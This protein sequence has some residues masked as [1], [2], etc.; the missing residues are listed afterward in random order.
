[1]ERLRARHRA[2]AL[3]RRDLL[4]DLG[5]GGLRHALLGLHRALGRTSGPLAQAPD[6]ARLREDEQRQDGDPQQRREGDDRADLREFCGD[7]E[8]EQRDAH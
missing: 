6:L 1:V 5:R 7:R 8:G 2:N 3:R 4:L